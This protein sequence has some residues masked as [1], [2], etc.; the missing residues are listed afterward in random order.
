MEMINGDII[1]LTYRNRAGKRLSRRQKP[2]QPLLGHAGGHRDACSSAMPTSK[3]TLRKLFGKIRQSGSCRHGC[4]NGTNSGVISALT[5]SNPGQ[6]VQ[7]SFPAAALGQRAT[8]FLEGTNPVEIIGIFL[9]RTKS[10]SLHRF[11]ME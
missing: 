1:E 3:K 6:S 11:H 8:L 9:R 5:P 7:K 10:L 2:E 4:C